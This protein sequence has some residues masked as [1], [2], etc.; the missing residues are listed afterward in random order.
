MTRTGIA[1]VPAALAA[2]LAAS[3]ALGADGAEK[4]SQ[5][6]DAT[7]TGVEQVDENCIPESIRDGLEAF[8]RQSA[9]Q[10]D[11]AVE[12]ARELMAE[13]RAASDR[14]G[15]KLSGMSEEAKRQWNETGAAV[16]KNLEEAEINLEELRT[17]AAEKWNETRG[18]VADALERAANALQ[19]KDE[20]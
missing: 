16:R 20:S 4:D 12:A 19:E 2:M 5:S 6:L 3:P 9:E 10:R 15:E 14:A 18:A 7:R 8:R 1:I 17:V 11:A 13:L